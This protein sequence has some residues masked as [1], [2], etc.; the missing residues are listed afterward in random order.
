LVDAF[1]WVKVPG[2]SDGSSDG[3]A[4]RYDWHCSSGDSFIPAPQ[5]GLWFN[6]FF[7]M[8]AQNANPP[9]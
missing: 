8:L 5:A 4:P 3:G 6:D 2:E 1:A 9:L 7:V